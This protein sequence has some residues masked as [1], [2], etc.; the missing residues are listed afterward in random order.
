MFNVQILSFYTVY[1]KW[2]QF[3]VLKHTCIYEDDWLCSDPAASTEEKIWP[4]ALDLF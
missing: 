2:S 3:K 1:K 4:R